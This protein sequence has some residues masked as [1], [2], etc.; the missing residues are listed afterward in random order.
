MTFTGKHESE[1]VLAEVLASPIRV[2]TFSVK[3][4]FV[5]SVVCAMGLFF[6]GFFLD[7]SVPLL[8]IFCFMEIIVLWRSI[9]YV[10]KKRRKRRFIITNERVLKLQKH[11]QN[12][13][14]LESIDDISLAN[15]KKWVGGTILINSSSGVFKVPYISQAE[16][17]ANFLNKV[18]RIRKTGGSEFPVFKVRRGGRY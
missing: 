8:W 6:A 2:F 5:V 10:L 3:V 11:E 13:V 4:F 17:V 18:V 1:Q 14:L 15:K 16:D 12:S 9:V 7:D